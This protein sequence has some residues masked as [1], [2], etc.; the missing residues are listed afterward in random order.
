MNTPS[1]MLEVLG[2]PGRSPEIPEEAD[3]YGWLVGDWDAEVVDYSVGDEPFKS[4]GEWHFAWVLE[5]RAIQDVW[6]VPP[7]A[8]RSP[9]TSKAGNRYGST[10]RVYDPALKAWRIIW[11]NPVSGAQNLMVGSRR[12]NDV[13]QEATAPDG[14]LTRWSFV[15]I[16]SDSFRWVG[17][18]SSDNGKTWRLWAEFR[19][20]KAAHH[21]TR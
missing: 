15:D 2:A 4:R 6:I 3:I 18:Q 8:E 5:G 9:A 14:S 12:G 16:T 11:I 17:E 20:R 21:K 7:I 10:L 1:R 13:V 19:L